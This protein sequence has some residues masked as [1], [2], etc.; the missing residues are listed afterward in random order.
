MIC[1][2]GL[3][4]Q[5]GLQIAKNGKK[6]LIAYKHKSVAGFYYGKLLHLPKY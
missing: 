2:E 3:C 4:E 6:K 5:K 1:S